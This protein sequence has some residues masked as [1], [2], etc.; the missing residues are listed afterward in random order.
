MEY[1][2]S[3]V[4]VIDS[5]V[6]VHRNYERRKGKKTGGKWQ[7]VNCLALSSHPQQATTS[8]PLP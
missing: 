2:V 7:V 8:Q 6:S 5:I 3:V 1:I 4:I